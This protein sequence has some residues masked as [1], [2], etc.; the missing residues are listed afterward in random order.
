MLAAEGVEARAASWPRCS[1]L[2]KHEA[3]GGGAMTAAGAGG[4]GR[5]Q[6]DLPEETAAVQPVEADQRLHVLPQV[7]LGV[8]NLPGLVGA[9]HGLV[10][11]T[12]VQRAEPV[13]L[14]GRILRGSACHPPPGQGRGRR[15]CAR[16]ENRACCARA[17][18]P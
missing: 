13:A 15:R 9:H 12:G 1:V 11:P 5:G 3:R 16:P 4:G 8:C 2:Q 10:L 6:G 17:E 18:G 14:P 7:P